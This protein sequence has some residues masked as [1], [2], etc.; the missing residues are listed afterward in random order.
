MLAQTAR[1]IGRSFDRPFILCLVFFAFVFISGS[2]ARAATLPAGFSE[3][4][5]AGGLAQPTTMAFAPDGRLFVCEQGG[6]VRVI[7][8]GVLLSTAFVTLNVSS[9]GE[10][11][12]LGIAFDPNFASNQFVYIY[13]TA[14]TP[15]IHNRISRFTANGDVALAGSEIPLLDLPNLSATNHNGGQLQFGPDG[16]LY[17]GVGENA[18]GENAQSLDTPLGKIL[19]INPDG[20]IPTDNPFYMATTGN[21][22]AIWALGLRNPFSLSFDPATGVLFINDVGQNTW[23]EINEGVRGANYGWPITEGPTSDGRFVSPL[24]SYNHSSGGVCS[25][26]GSVFY[27]PPSSQFPASYQG[28]YFFGD[29]CAGWIRV[30][31]PATNSVSDFAGGISA[32]VALQVGRDGSLY[33]LLR[34]PSSTA[35]A[36]FQI[37]FSEAPSISSQP[38]DQT[39]TDGQTVT[40]SVSA[41]GSGP[42]SFQ[43][44]RN[45]QDIPGATDS[46]LTFTARAGDNGATFRTRVSNG[47]GSAVSNRAT[48]TVTPVTNPDPNPNPNT[49]ALEAESLPRSS[50]GNTTSLQTDPSTSGGAWIMLQSDN[51]WDYVEF[52]TPTLSPGWYLVKFRYKSYINRGQVIVQVD[53]DAVGRTIDQY[54]ESPTYPEITL[55]TVTFDGSGTHRIRVTVTGRNGAS[56]GFIAS[57]DQFTFIRL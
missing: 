37:R 30:L 45:D 41:S 1:P 27:R 42:L 9:V 44:Q 4:Q 8:E 34:G 40:F 51:V 35:G 7:K 39:V 2:S 29:Y 23:E 21:S 5:I 38:Q 57:A 11:G 22:R 13:Y 52:T 55:G 49:V 25:I 3:T 16:K 56:S 33:Y 24:Y 19:R 26:V 15:A 47:S 18:V 10:R 12:V 28:K 14:T 17:L 6:R 53:G 48:L 54:N 31:D 50:P 46:N 36:V 43:W 20:S 32:L